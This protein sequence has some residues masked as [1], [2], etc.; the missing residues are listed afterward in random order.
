[1]IDMF[2]ELYRSCG[3]LD[4]MFIGIDD[5]SFLRLCLQFLGIILKTF[6]PEDWHVYR[7]VWLEGDTRLLRSRIIHLALSLMYVGVEE[8]DSIF[9][10]SR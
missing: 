1:M 6:N 5:F 7:I 9:I 2:I 3:W 8:F 10:T 4:C